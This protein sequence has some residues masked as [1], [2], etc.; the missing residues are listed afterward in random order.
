MALNG[1]GLT[2]RALGDTAGAATAFRKSLGLDP[3][4]PDIARA[5]AE[6]RR[7]GATE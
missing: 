3:N 4:Q 7:A 2:R 6:I 5:L 1:L